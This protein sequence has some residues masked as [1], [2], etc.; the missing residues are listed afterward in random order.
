MNLENKVVVITGGTKGIGYSL[1][2][3]FKEEKAKVV[4]CA[5][6]ADELKQTADELDVIGIKTDITKENEVQSLADQTVNTFG[7]IDIWVNNAGSWMSHDYVEDFDIEKVRKMFDVNFFGTLFSVRSVV[8]EM[9]KQNNGLILNVISASALVGRPKSS[10]YAS[11][12]WAVRG[13]TESLKEELKDTHIQTF[14]VYPIG[15]KTAIFDT[16]RAPADYDSYMEAGDV[17]KMVIDNL[18]KDNPEVDLFIK[19]PLS[20]DVQRS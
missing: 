14:A 2:K 7:K 5:R 19:K 10:M 4:V 1:A 6:N 16:E 13:L 11:S 15:T 17:A 3:A 12:K 9:K 18:R 20:P 8:K